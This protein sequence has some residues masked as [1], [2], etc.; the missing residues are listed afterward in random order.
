MFDLPDGFLSRLPGQRPLI[1]HHSIPEIRFHVLVAL[2]D[3]LLRNVPIESV[4]HSSCHRGDGGGVSSH[5]YGASYDIF[6]AI[7]FHEASEGRSKSVHRRI[8]SLAC[9]PV[10]ELSARLSVNH[11]IL[12]L[13]SLQ[14]SLQVRFRQGEVYPVA[15]FHREADIVLAAT[16]PGL[17]DG[18]RQCLRTLDAVRMA[19]SELRAHPGKIDSILEV[20]YAQGN[21][22]DSCD[23]VIGIPV[24]GLEVFAPA[25]YAHRRGETAA[26]IS[27]VGL[28][29]AGY[30]GA[31]AVVRICGDPAGDRKGHDCCICHL[32]VEHHILSAVTATHACEHLEFTVLGVHSFVWRRNDVP[33]NSSK[34][35]IPPSSIAFC[36][37]SGPPSWSSPPAA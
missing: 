23:R 35:T 2:L 34:H 29:Q 16:M 31:L 6:E 13:S 17:P 1:G 11:H 14:D 24:E 15:A 12:L 19:V 3:D 4:S 25:P 30:E 10:V 9:R 8:V 26:W 36:L 32:G 27:V 37:S 22:R 18:F 21:R 7:A 20:A 33:C 28:L 5:S